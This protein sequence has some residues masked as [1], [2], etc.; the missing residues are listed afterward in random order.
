MAK[1]KTDIASAPEDFAG[2]NDLILRIHPELPKR[3]AQTAKFAIEHPDEIAFGTAASVA[4][5]THGQPSTLVRLA[6]ALGYS[7]FSQMQAVFR[8]RLI[9]RTPSY[10]ERLEALRTHSGGHG[11]SAGALLASFADAAG[12][13]LSALRE[14]TDLDRLE[15]AVAVLANAQTIYVAGQRRSY[16]V[17]AYLGYVLAKLGIR[18]TLLASSTG[19]EA[20]MLSEV[21]HEDAMLAI[22]FAPYA[23][24]TLALAASA[25][26]E[27]VP[28]VAITDGPFSPLAAQA[29]VWL[30]VVE[31]D[32][33]GFRNPAATFVLV[34]TL[35]VAVA[36]RR[37]ATKKPGR[38]GPR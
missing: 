8:E 34:M 30:E 10:A 1:T 27:G 31:A 33:D 17:A 4:A 16:P 36:E 19:I 25:A 18:H 7:G 6:Q 9:E 12:R 13:S 2:L 11:G 20:E 15:A 22:S 38:A 28:L 26:E 37:S 21:G 23:P 3:L 35:A 14:Q 5:R 29:K 24:G 32:L